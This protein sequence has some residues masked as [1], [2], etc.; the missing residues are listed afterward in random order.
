MRIERI[1]EKKAQAIYDSI[2]SNV[3]LARYK[4]HDVELPEIDMHDYFKERKSVNVH[5]LIK[6]VVPT[7]NNVGKEAA[8]DK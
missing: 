7:L 5:E 1:T 3:R 4:G 2:R 8:N 6:Q